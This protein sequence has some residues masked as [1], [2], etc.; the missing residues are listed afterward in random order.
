MILLCCYSHNPV[1]AL[2]TDR[3]LLQVSRGRSLFDSRSFYRPG[4]NWTSA[5]QHSRDTPLSMTT[6]SG[7]RG[8]RRRVALSSLLSSEMTLQGCSYYRKTIL[9]M[10]CL[11]TGA[12]GYSCS[13]PLLS[14]LS[15]FYCSCTHTHPHLHWH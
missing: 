7:C 14:F 2:V 5:C 1:A 8:R 12:A 11:D 13:R 6:V 4:H 15:L 10:W 9:H 3:K